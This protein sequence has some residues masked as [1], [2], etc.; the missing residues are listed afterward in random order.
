[1]VTVSVTATNKSMLVQPSFRTPSAG[2]VRQVALVVL[3]IAMLFMIPMTRRF[4]SRLGLA[5][6]MLV[7]VVLAGCTGHGHHAT[8]GTATITGTSGTVSKTVTVNLNIT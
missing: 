3:G 8:T 1:M 2:V 6:A 4:R 5:G 7:F